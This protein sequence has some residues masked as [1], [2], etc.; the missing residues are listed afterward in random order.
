MPGKKNPPNFLLYG[1][2][3]IST[4]IHIFI[5]LHIAGIYSSSAISYI[6]LSM[7]QI[8]KPDIRAI[9][10]PRIREK[11][12][13]ISEARIVQSNLMKIPQIKI[14]E[15]RHEKPDLTHGQISLPEIPDN[16]N[17]SG[18][19]A[20]DFESRLSDIHTGQDEMEFTSIKEYF[21]MLNLRIHRFKEYPESARS[22]HLQGNVKLEFVLTADGTLDDIKIIR[23]S[24]HKV[25]DDAAIRAVE[26]A[27]PFPRPPAF[28]F[29]P[30]VTLQISVLFELA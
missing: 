7:Q 2:I 25:L 8:S 23:S 12:P 28:L 14:D 26:N 30:P 17:I 24:R 27:S 10:K 22:N 16:L 6:E 5:F 21:E 19:L 4:G 11:E 15:V 20:A 3:F 18:L 9:P 29:R 1:F 13:R